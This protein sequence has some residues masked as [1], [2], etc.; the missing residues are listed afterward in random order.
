MDEILHADRSRTSEFAGKSF[1]SSAAIG[2]KQAQVHAFTGGRTAVLRTGDG[3]FQTRSFADR[4]SFRTRGFDTK[5]DRAS[6]SDAF[7][8]RDRGFATKALPVQ[9]APGTGKVAPGV[10]DYVPGQKNIVIRGKRQDTID[11]IHNQKDLSIDEVREILNKPNGR[12]GS[13]PAV[14]AL[15]AMRATSLPAPTAQ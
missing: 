15:P 13:K 1:A 4:D 7:A 8:Q 3:A 5:A 2:G 10:R 6:H 14:E 9:D 11:E 12:P